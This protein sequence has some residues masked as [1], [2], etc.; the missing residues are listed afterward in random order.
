MGVHLQ[1]LIG[2][3]LQFPLQLQLRADAGLLLLLVC[4]VAVA[5]VDGSVADEWR[6]VSASDVCD[7]LEAVGT[8]RQGQGCAFVAEL[9][10]EFFVSSV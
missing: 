2:P 1:T 8:G 4:A 10:A 6:A 7:V 9:A 5:A 3:S